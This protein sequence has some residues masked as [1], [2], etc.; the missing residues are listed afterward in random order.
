MYSNEYCLHLYKKADISI[1][2]RLRGTVI[3]MMLQKVVIVMINIVL[4]NV[5][6]I[7]GINNSNHV[8]VRPL[9]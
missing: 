1:I 2:I 3:E 8:Y 6:N 7:Y 9:F 5:H 4:N